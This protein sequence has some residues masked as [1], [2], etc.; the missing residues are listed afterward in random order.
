MAD[1]SEKVIL[2]LGLID[3]LLEWLKIN[4]ESVIQTSEK[5][6]PEFIASNGISFLISYG[7]RHILRKMS[8]SYCL[9][10]Q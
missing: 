5:I 8:L 9:T 7:Y 3:P 4:G 1:T 2:F 10:G 6:T